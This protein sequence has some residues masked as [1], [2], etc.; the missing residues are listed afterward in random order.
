MA[1]YVCPICGKIWYNTS[2]LAK[3]VTACDKTATEVAK[4]KEAQALKKNADEVN[5]KKSRMAVQ[6]AYTALRKA[7]NEYNA[8][9]TEFSALYGETVA[10]CTSTFSWKD[11]KTVQN[12]VRNPWGNENKLDDLKKAYTIKKEDLD[13][14]L[15]KEDLSKIIN[16]IFNF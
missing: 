1:K 14:L 2:D 8:A 13:S 5:L 9:A 4:K 12:R 3:C 16:D 15:S 10:T 7:V 11:T 6:E